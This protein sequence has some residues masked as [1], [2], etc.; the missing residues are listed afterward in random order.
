M[1]TRERNEENLKIVD[2]RYRKCSPS[3]ELKANMDYFDD[4]Y[5]NGFIC[6]Y[7]ADD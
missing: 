4:S 3:L 2:P 7:V 1:F 5:M 6:F